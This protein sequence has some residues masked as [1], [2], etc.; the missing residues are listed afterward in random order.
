MRKLTRPFLAI[1]LLAAPSLLSAGFLGVSGL[2]PVTGKTAPEAGLAEE[3]T[4]IRIGEI[5]A[6]SP[7]EKAKLAAGD[8]L[9]AVDDMD[10]SEPER[11]VQKIGK[12]PAGT[13]VS[14][15]YLRGGKPLEAR[16]VLGKPPAQ[17]NRPK[18]GIEGQKAPAWSSAEWQNLPEGKTSL[19]IGDFSGK[20]V[21]LFFFQS[22]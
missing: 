10:A 3:Q 8:I 22:W 16:I 18:G 19:D 9:L 21:Y 20:V 2:E 15:R 17:G 6:G 7:A 13:E 1:F 14:V 5:V 12:A 11:L 4:G